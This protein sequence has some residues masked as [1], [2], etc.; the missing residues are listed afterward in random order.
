MK[1]LFEDFKRETIIGDE[2]C[3][4]YTSLLP[5]ELIRIWKQYGFG[6][7]L[8]GYLKII[9][10]QDYQELLKETYFRGNEAIPIFATAFADIITWEKGRYIRI[11]KYKNGTFEGIAAGF[12]FFWSDLADGVFD[13]RFFELEKYD[14]A[15][16]KFGTIEFDECFG[17]TPLLG[18]GGSE[19]VD[20]LRKGKIREHI[21]IISQLVGKI[22]M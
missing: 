22:G 13:N 16:K 1:H 14:A 5:D 21:E 8:N 18:L 20:N 7:L 12:K 11:V 6:S 15:I 2:F 9:N 4:Q 10:P 19:K 3:M 17:Y